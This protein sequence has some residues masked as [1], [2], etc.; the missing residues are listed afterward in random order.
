MAIH[1]LTVKQIVATTHGH[2]NDG[3]GLVLRISSHQGCWRFRYTSPARQRRAMSFGTAVVRGDSKLIEQ[4]L[5]DAREIAAEA[6]SILSRGQDP[7]DL[8]NTTKAHAHEQLRVKKSAR[9]KEQTTVARSARA[10]HE[11]VIENSRTPLHARHWI[12]SLENHLPPS[13]WHAPV[14]SIMAPVLLDAM[15]EIQRKVPETATRIRQRLEAVFNDAELRG[16]CATNPART[17]R[18]PMAEALVK[19]QR[20]AL[21]ALPYTEVPAFMANLRQCSGIAARALEFAILTAARTGEVIGATWDEVHLETGVWTV[22]GARMKGGEQH[23]VYLSDAAIAIARAMQE[24]KQSFVFPSPTLDGSPLS[25]MA[26]LTL[27]RR[28]DAEKRTTV[29]GLCRAS[30]STWANETGAARPDVIEA[31]LAHREGNLVRK[32]YNRAQFNSER[33]ALLARW[34][35]YCVGKLFTTA[36]AP[37]SAVVIRLAA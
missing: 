6:R 16:L 14:D 33:K 23:T 10:Y 2:L 26:M 4:S 30:F 5:R 24:N 19:R 21:A 13:I 3:G 37:P 22:A 11:A 17:I 36:D 29:H 8:R 9:K 31:C 25:N 1:L 32:A 15:I 27:L 18:R 12:D 35:Q 20:R 34:G 28:M 7:L